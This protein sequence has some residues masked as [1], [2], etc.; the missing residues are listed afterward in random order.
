MPDIKTK[1]KAA[2]E[3][4]NELNKQLAIQDVIIRNAKKKKLKL[5]KKIS[6]NMKYR[7][8]LLYSGLK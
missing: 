7:V 1:L 8:S 2:H 6:E 3:R 4:E 5:A